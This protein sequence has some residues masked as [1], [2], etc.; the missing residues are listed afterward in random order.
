MVVIIGHD[1]QYDIYT[2]GYDNWALDG[3]KLP[4]TEK[5]G[6]HGLSTIKNCRMGSIAIGTDGTSKI[7]KGE[8]AEWVDL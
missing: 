3:D 6:T 8:T 2:F 1:E 4:T 7:L 5:A